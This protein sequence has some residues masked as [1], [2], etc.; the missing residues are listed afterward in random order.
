MISKLFNIFRIFRKI[1][2]HK[3]GS[4]MTPAEL[5]DG[6]FDI[7]VPFVDAF[8]EFDKPLIAA[9]NGPSV[10]IGCSSLGLCDLVL[11][12]KSGSILF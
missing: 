2:I 4:G 1:K 7:M 11:A 9:V 8:I 10:G 5:A 6:A 12:R 3:K